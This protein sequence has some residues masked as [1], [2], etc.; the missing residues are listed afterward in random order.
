VGLIIFN[1]DSKPEA[2][3]IDVSKVYL[4]QKCVKV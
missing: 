3:K 2:A 1:V 4:C